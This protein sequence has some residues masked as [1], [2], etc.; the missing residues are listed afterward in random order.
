MGDAAGS[1]RHAMAQSAMPVTIISF[2][3]I[4]SLL[5]IDKFFI[6]FSTEQIVP[7]DADSLLGRQ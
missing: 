5:A 2:I 3:L 7:M 4:F 1:A 6:L